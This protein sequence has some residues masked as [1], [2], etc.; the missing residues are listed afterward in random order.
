MNRKLFFSAIAVTL[1]TF[2]AFSSGCGSSTSSLSGSTATP[3]TPSDP[4]TPEIIESIVGSE[5]LLG[6]DSNSNNKPDVLDF[7]NVQHLYSE[8]DGT[9]LH[10]TVPFM[11]W[12]NSLPSQYSPDIITTELTAGTAYTFEVSRNLAD[13]L[14]GRIPDVDIFDPSGNEVATTLTVYPEEQ[15]SMLLFTFTP[16]VSGTYTAL[17]CNADGNAE[18]DTDCVLFVYKE[19]FNDLGE[20]GYYAH[21]I[22]S[23]VITSNQDGSG[24]VEASIPEIIQLRKNFLQAYPNYLADVY[25]EHRTIN[26][27]TAN[28][29]EYSAWLSI[30]NDHAG[31]IELTSDDEE[32]D[33]EFSD[34]EYSGEVNAAATSV[35]QI[36][37]TVYNVPYVDE[38]QLGTGLMATTNLQALSQTG[39]EDFTL[40]VPAAGEKIGTTRFTYSFISSKEEYEQKMG[41]NFKMGLATSALG[42]S[43]G[44][45]ST[46][47]LKFGLTST[48]LVIHYEELESKYRDLPLKQYKL[49]ND[50]MELLSSDNE[51]DRAAFRE[52]YG[53]YFVA[54]YQYGG[55]YEA[56][57]SITTE[58]T[59][60]LDKVKSEIGVSIGDMNAALSGDTSKEGTNIGAKFSQETQETL[61][62]NKA[63]IT[64][65]IKTIG[66]G[67]TTPTNIPLANSHDISAMSN[68]A[69]E[70][71]KFRN[72]MAD[73]FTTNTYVPVNVEFK[74]YR[75]LPGMRKKIAAY[76]PV[77]AEHS[78]NIMSFNSELAAL[79]GYYNVIGTLPASKM[80]TL[81]RDDYT[82][83]FN[84]IVNPIKAGGNAFYNSQKDIA[85]TLP[86][87]ISLSREL[88]IA[89]DR[90]SFYNMLVSAQA[91][92]NAIDI[93]KVAVINQP[94]NGTNGGSTGYKSFG[95]STA[96]TNDIE[97]GK[98]D[99]DTH[100]ADE[101]IFTTN[102]WKP[103]YD[104]GTDYRFSWFQVTAANPNDSGRKVDNPPAVGKQKASF[105]FESGGTRTA[106]WK[107]E[108]QSVY[109]PRS[110]Y[111]FFGLQD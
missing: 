52:E 59:E 108:R 75:S 5:I 51:D 11:V 23:N 96:V 56:H 85:E 98:Y 90:L 8:T 73:S 89:G 58:T 33:E 13:S 84:A 40:N 19:L 102:D 18:G 71:M 34:A 41:R 65:E 38:Y 32:E 37:T 88:K 22:I 64:V 29:E 109:M 43:S 83:K 15:P 31:I 68:V 36:D 111:P 87:V 10:G 106:D 99:S 66:A 94:F 1:L 80:D 44:V 49:T 47:N 110:L 35:T 92:E 76:I 30:L 45:Q 101:K 86:K 21:F 55:M 46:N 28:L 72:S 54:G 57:I 62:K 105:H 24:T 6:L 67:K 77:P 82:R 63:E 16:A 81:V 48:T 97:Q 2:F 25:V 20:A 74:R 79:R 9:E 42:I 93:S 95:L 69:E 27:I 70:L 3:D 14:G 61:K 4:D 26:D 78:A 107:I 39:I 17:I 53:D 103:S 50:A 60:Q 7:D 104:A 12:M 91:K 100:K